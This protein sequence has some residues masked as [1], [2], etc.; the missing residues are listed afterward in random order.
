MN[1]NE[2]LLPNET[3]QID[4]LMYRGRSNE[5]RFTLLECNDRDQKVKNFFNINENYS[6]TCVGFC[7]D[8]APSPDRRKTYGFI[9]DRGPRGV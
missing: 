1:R 9:R 3:N 6:S 2:V 5:G 8:E 4:I 7:S